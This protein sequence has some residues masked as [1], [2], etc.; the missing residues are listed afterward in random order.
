MADILVAEY[1]F[2]EATLSSNFSQV[3][4]GAITISSSTIFSGAHFSN[5]IAMAYW[6]ADAFDV[7]QWS[8]IEMGAFGGNEG[9]VMATG[10]GVRI[11]TGVDPNHNGYWAAPLMTGSGNKQTRI[12]KILNGT[13]ETL[14]TGSAVAWTTGDLLRIRVTG[15]APAVITVY[16]NGVQVATATDSTSPL[17]TGKPGPV[18]R[19]NV[20]AG[21]FGDNWKGGNVLSGRASRNT[22][23]H[24]LGFNLGMNLG[25]GV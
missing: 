9:D 15:V 17:T 10:A 5:P 25:M 16:R 14:D 24:P 2:N 18:S 11:G 7:D 13:P 4:D 6:N 12:Q 21:Y 19:G 8:E 1:N 3:G 22:S 20:A 23:S